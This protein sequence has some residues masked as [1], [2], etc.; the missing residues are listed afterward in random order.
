MSRGVKDFEKFHIYCDEAGTS[1]RFTIIGLIFC[2][3][4]VALKFEPWLEEIAQRHGGT[5]EVKWTKAKKHNLR[6]YKEFSSAFFRARNRNLAHYYC[7]VIDNSKMNHKLY[8]EGD[9]ELGFNKMLFQLL[10]KMVREYRHRPRLY[11]YLDHRTTKHTPE[12]LREMLN[13]KAA[14]D[15]HVTH[16]P[17]RVCHFRQSHESRMIQLADVITGAICYRANRKHLLV[18]AADYKKELADHIEREA[19]VLSLSAPTRFPSDGFDVWHID[20]TARAR[21]VRRP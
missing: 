16:F 9:K 19:R 21:G 20:L 17:Y 14:R 10:Y 3:E 2:A 11:A 4:R 13:A 7:I 8:N 18:G 1:D 12:R 15:L 6:L 5:S